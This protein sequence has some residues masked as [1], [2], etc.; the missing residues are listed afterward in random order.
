MPLN[1]LKQFGKEF[2]NHPY[3]NA[4]NSRTTH[5]IKDMNDSGHEFPLLGGISI[6]QMKKSQKNNPIRVI[7]QTDQGEF[8]LH[9]Y[10]L[11]VD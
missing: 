5:P 9:S 11:L 10:S 4:G 7:S 3:V 1:S 2:C 8:Y 6:M